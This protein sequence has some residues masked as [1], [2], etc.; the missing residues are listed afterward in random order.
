MAYA[1]DAI[2]L[3][4]YTV[5]THSRGLKIIMTA[6]RPSPANKWRF[7]CQIRTGLD[8]WLDQIKQLF[9]QPWSALTS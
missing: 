3:C 6:G 5:E 4:S 1:M 2:G 9:Q 7:N 8:F